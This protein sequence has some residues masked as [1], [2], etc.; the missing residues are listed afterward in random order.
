ML[1]PQPENGRSQRAGSIGLTACGVS[2][3]LDAFFLRVSDIPSKTGEE[4]VL[5]LAIMEALSNKT[6]SSK[7]FQAVL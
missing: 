1:F 2:V 4:L 5:A 7:L 6:S 3:A